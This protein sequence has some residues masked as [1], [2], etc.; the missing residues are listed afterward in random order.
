MTSR[1]RF[2]LTFTKTFLIGSLTPGE[3]GLDKDAH[4]SLGRVSA[5]D[6]AKAQPF[7]PGPL[8]KDD[9]VQA[10]VVQRAEAGRQLGHV[11]SG[12][13]SGPT[14]TATVRDVAL[15]KGWLVV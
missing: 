13:G 4:V 6:H 12:R 14:C 8:F 9:R 11:G 15:G 5:P 1:S 3:N 10:V 2:S 7:Q